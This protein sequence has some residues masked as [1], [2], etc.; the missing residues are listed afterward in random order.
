MCSLLPRADTQVYGLLTR[1]ITEVQV[2]RRGAKTSQCRSRD[3]VVQ[4]PE[5]FFPP[6]RNN[7][8]PPGTGLC[9]RFEVEVWFH[10]RKT[11]HLDCIMMCLKA[12]PVWEW[13]IL[14]T[15]QAHIEH[16]LSFF[17]VFS[18]VMA[19][20]QMCSA[21]KLIIALGTHKDYYWTALFCD[22]PFNRRATGMTVPEMMKDGGRVLG[23][24]GIITLI[25]I[26]TEARGWDHGSTPLVT[27]VVLCVTIL[28][29]KEMERGKMSYS[30]PETQ[31]WSGDQTHEQGKIISSCCSLTLRGHFSCLLPPS[32]VRFWMGKAGP[33][34]N[35]TCF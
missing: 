27:T 23:T 16:M 33:A 2:Q 25:C 22:S 8:T 24:K 20:V 13:L 3:T 4:G 32:W 6:S 17:S 9:T 30:E 12:T 10:F 21:W 19:L 18:A 14:P 15:G 34:T 11:Q 5:S 31:V 7:P 35:G 1:V 29:Y 28:T 26:V